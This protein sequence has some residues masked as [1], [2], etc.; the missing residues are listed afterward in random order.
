MKSSGQWEITPYTSSCKAE[1]D[2]FVRTSRN[3]TFLFMRDYMDY[4]ADRFR[5]CSL[6]ARYGGKLHALLPAHLSGKRFC[7]HKGLTYGG[8]VT[9]DKMTASLML[10][11][12]D[13]VI[14]YLRTIG[15]ETWVYAPVPYIYARY[16]S[17]EDLYALFRHGACLSERK[18]STVIPSDCGKP[19]STL[20]K[21]KV[22]HARACGL[23]VRQSDDFAG[24]WSILEDNLKQRHQASPVH[25]LDEIR[26]LHQRFPSQILLYVVTDSQGG[27]LA[28]TVLYL[29]E[30]V[31]HVQ[32]IG[33]TPEGRELGAVD[34]LFDHL[35]HHVYQ[36]VPYFDMGTSVEDG[37]RWL[38]EGLIFQKE[39]F[40]GRA[41]V[42]DTYE[43]EIRTNKG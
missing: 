38:N 20:R 3:G 42:Y 39:G 40:G 34:L 30:K 12:F 19:F 17:E 1:W 35:I 2:A 13:Q 16:P 37:G 29:T 22:K 4:H 15:V 25:S 28:G 10:S 6:M 26:L 36:G 33:S 31:V 32:Y 5:D 18:I 23:I 14:C 11:L 8:V 41:V 7:S 24:F 9:D 43:L 27:L 21:R